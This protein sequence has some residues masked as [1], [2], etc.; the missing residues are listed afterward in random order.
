MPKR[1]KT[2]LI[3]R[4]TA[5][6]LEEIAELLDKDKRTCFRWIAEGLKVIEVDAKPL[7]VM[8]NELKRF[9]EERR[10]KNKVSMEKDEYYCLHCRKPSKAKFGS[11][12]INPTGKNIGKDNREQ[13]MKIG[14]CEVCDGKIFRLC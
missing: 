3:R 7:L 8:G 9:L 11:E 6:T 13:M 5:Y 2:N 10:N 4:R 12:K 14:L 1:Y